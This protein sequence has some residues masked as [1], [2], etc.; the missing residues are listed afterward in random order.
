MHGMHRGNCA[1]H[2]IFVLPRLSFIEKFFNK[3]G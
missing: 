2:P 3:E 1:V